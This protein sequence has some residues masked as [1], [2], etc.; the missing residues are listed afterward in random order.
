MSQS[1]ILSL[2]E[3]EISRL[4]AA[5]ILLEAVSKR[6]PGRP[7]STAVESAK[8]NNKKKRTISSEGLARIVEGQRKRWAKQKKAAK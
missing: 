7:K 3:A 1:D 4:Q 5:R 2:I 6:K 8:P